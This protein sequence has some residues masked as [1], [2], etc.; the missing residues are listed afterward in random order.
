MPFSTMLLLYPFWLTEI[1]ICHKPHP[2]RDEMRDLQIALPMTLMLP[3]FYTSRTLHVSHIHAIFELWGRPFCLSLLVSFGVAMK[4]I[5]FTQ[6]RWH[7][8]FLSF[9]R[10]TTCFLSSRGRLL[11]SHK[12]QRFHLHIQHATNL[13]EWW[14]LVGSLEAVVCGFCL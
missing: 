12:H 5:Q 3:F 13:F 8:S 4:G 10:F 14:T 9:T 1:C 2:T 6:L 7:I 11:N